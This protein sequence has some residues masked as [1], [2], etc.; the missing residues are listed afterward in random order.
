MPMDSQPVAEK[1]QIL[2]TVCFIM[3]SFSFT[4]NLLPAS[5]RVEMTKGEIELYTKSH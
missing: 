5:I 2:E 3:S 4:L 1:E